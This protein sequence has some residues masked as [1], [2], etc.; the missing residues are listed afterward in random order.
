MNSF[1]SIQKSE[2]D[3]LTRKRLI[4]PERLYRNLSAKMNLMA[5]YYNE[6]TQ[7]LSRKQIDR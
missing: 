1:H 6:I 7:Q 3:H 2:T 4:E 5:L